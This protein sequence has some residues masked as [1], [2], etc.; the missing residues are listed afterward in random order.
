MP[1]PAHAAST[2]GRPRL[3]SV[4]GYQILEELGRGGMGVV[5]RAQEVQL[6]RVVALKM[7]LAADHANSEAILRFHSE[8]EMVASLH[9]HNIVQ[10]HAIGECDGRPYFNLEYVEGGSLAARLD[11]IP[12]N[13]RDAAAL[14]EALARGIHEAHKHSVVHRDIKPA[15]ILLT[16]EG[17]PKISDFGLAKTLNK[18]SDLTRT[19]SIMGSPSYMS[20]E[21]AHGHARS[22]G[23]G[24]D[25]Y[26]LG[27]NFYELLTGRPPFRGSS[28]LETLD[29]VKNSEPV[30]P[31]RLVPGLPRD[32]ETIC[33]KCLEKE[34]RKRYES[35]Q[36]LADDLKRYLHNEPILARRVGA[37]ERVWKWALRRP[38]AAALVLVTCLMF[39]TAA[40]ATALHYRTLG[41]NFELRRR[42]VEKLRVDANEHLMKAAVA[43]EKRDWVNAKAHASNSFTLAESESSLSQIRDKARSLLGESDALISEERAGRLAQE[44]IQ[45]F[46]QLRD[47]ALFYQSQYTGLGREANLRATREASRKAIEVIAASTAG[48]EGRPED[49]TTAGREELR[50]GS[51]ELH[52]ALAEALGEP[53]P[54]E[55]PKSQCRLALA[56]L[57]S[58]A[59]VQRPTRAYHR[60]RAELLGH[61]DDPAA[62]A[63]RAV[64][65]GEAVADYGA[66][67][68]FLL[69]ASSYRRNDWGRAADHFKKVLA[70]APE[71]FWAQ[72][73]LAIC[74]LKLQ[75]LAEARTGLTAC[76]ARRPDFV[77]IYLL[78]G[79][80]EGELHE[81]DLAAHDFEKA[82]TLPLTDEARY[83]LLVNRGVVNLRG[84]RPDAAISDFNAAVALRPGNYQAYLNLG[85]AFLNQ[86]R[87]GDALRTLDRAIALNS[88][89]ELI[90]LLRSQVFERRR[91][92]EA[93]LADL[94][95][96]AELVPPRDP[97]LSGIWFRQGRIAHRRKAHR[98]A[99]AAYDR[100]LGMEPENLTVHRLRGAVLMELGK[101]TEALR[102]FD[103]CLSRGKPTASLYEARGLAQTWRG[104]FES[105]ISDLSL[106]LRLGRDTS[107]LRTNLGWAFLF[108][109]A[110]RPA[111][112]EF[113][114]ALR[115][116]P[117]SVDALGD[118]GSP[119]RS[120][121]RPEKPW[122]TPKNCRPGPTATRG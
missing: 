75:R 27:A 80:A 53:L 121:S 41:N 108:S 1:L 54:G 47:E 28:I 113:S 110:A 111:L 33:L 58:A 18:D 71:H 72:Y 65:E 17:V 101:Y 10:I 16:Y 106:A 102:S 104:D 70:L 99:L 74:N 79:F 34:P 88:R 89:N 87:E 52:L 68:V 98:E 5:Y 24:S 118:V 43:F 42:R 55:D 93:A 112:R 30:A 76:Q 63:A 67:D 85:Q 59:G 44:R 105:A 66:V 49:A 57:D 22:V 122:P 56:V 90:Y 95:R 81:F 21:Q 15:N 19:E 32:L 115:R 26:A 9:H 4:P 23:I 64:A 77:W 25:I 97:Q 96:A 92:D 114:E 35:A 120:S 51:Y 116:D 107:A 48:P 61:L 40:G 13:P 3:P 39:L 103:V 11:G 86:G 7:I 62:A 6:N 73:L 46:R 12:W 45:R 69:G 78:K 37:G 60:L 82:L 100:V 2:T 29:Q 8:A 84:K 94:A 91:D 117:S 36:E 50:S 83:V 20:P 109:G 38:T 119:G 14:V 31:S